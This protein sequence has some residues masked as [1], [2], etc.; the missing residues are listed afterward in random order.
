MPNYKGHLVGGFAVYCIVLVMLIGTVP[1]LVTAF[2]WLLFALAGALFPDVDIKSKGQKYF[3]YLVFVI[4]ALLAYKGRFQVLSCCSFII[5]TPMLTRHRGIF[6]STWFVVSVP[7]VVWMVMSMLYPKL[8]GPFFF[9]TF[10]FITGA[11]SHLFLDRGFSRM[12][13]FRNRR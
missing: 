7:L 8:A 1:S 12:F 11:L 3:Y 10:F 9:D 13:R 4:F 6:H 5:I 2:E